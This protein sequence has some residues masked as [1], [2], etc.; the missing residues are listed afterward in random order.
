MNAYF[1]SNHSPTRSSYKTMRL[2]MLALAVSAALPLATG[3][4][5]QEV[6]STPSPGAN[7][8]DPVITAGEPKSAVRYSAPYAANAAVGKIEVEIAADGLAA[9]G[10]TPTAVTVKVFD[11]TGA[12]LNDDVVLTVE[13][14]AGRIQLPNA[15]T[16]ELG[17]R[18]L[19]GD[20]TTQGTQVKV[21][22]GIAQFNLL[23]PIEPQDVKMRVTAGDATAVGTISFL[24]EM[25]EMIAAGL[26]EGVVRFS[27]KDPALIRPVR[28]NDGFEQEL[29]QW[30][31]TFNN[32]KG[33]AATRAT[34]FIKGQVSG[35]TLLTAAYD[36]DK[37][38]RARLLRDIRPEAFYPVYGDASIRG[39][40]A[41]SSSK[42]YVRLDNGKSYAMYG[43]FSTGDGF[44]QLTAGGTSVVAK[45][46]QLGAYNRTLT[47]GRWH[48]EG[49]RGFLNVFA[50]NDSLKQVVEE[51]RANGTSGPY[52][53][54]NT[55]ALENSEKVEILVRDRNQ[56]N[57]LVREPVV[58]QRFVDYTFE[59]F[60]GKI[61]FKSPIPSLDENGNP[62]SI[63]VTYEVDQ[64]GEKFWLGGIDGQFNVTESFSLGGKIIEDRN[65]SSPYKLRSVNAGFKFGERTQLIAEVAQ[66]ESVGYINTNPL[67]GPVGQFTNPFAGSAAGRV[68]RDGNAYRLEFT[69]QG[70]QSRLRAY[71]GRAD[72]G[73]DN[74][75][76][77]WTGGKREAALQ[78]AF[79]ITEN[80]SI[81]GEAIRTEDSVTDGKRDGATLGG[82]FKIG[83]RFSLTGGV[84]KLRE[85]GLIGSQAF[86]AGNPSPG[87]LFNSTGGF[88]GGGIDPNQINPFSGQ[89]ITS[90][91]GGTPSGGGAGAD[92]DS[93]TVFL[94]ANWRASDKLTLSGLLESDVSGEDRKR[95]ELGAAYQLAERSR[96]YARAERQTG[97][98]SQYSLNQGDESNA[99]ILGIDNTYMSNSS[100]IGQ[101]FNEYRLRDSIEGREAQ[102][103][104]GLRNTFYLQEGLALSTSAEYLKI[105]DGTST[106][107]AAFTVG[108][109]YTQSEL[110]KGSGRLEVR[111]AFDNETTVGDDVQTSVLTTIAI[112][113]KLDR[114]WTALARNYYLRQYN[115]E[116]ATGLARPDGWQDRFQVGAAYRPVDNNR[117]DVLSKYEFLTENNI[118]GSG[119]NSDVHILSAHAIYH[120]SRPWWISGRIAGK[121]RDD[122]FGPADGN[123]RDKYSAWLLGGRVIYDFT[124]NWDFGVLASVLQGKQTGQTGDSRQYAYG[125]EAGRLLRQN[126]WLSAGY[127]WSGFSD[128][129]L[130]GTD[131]TN[132]GA[133]IR[134]RFKFDENLLRRDDKNINR[135]L[136]R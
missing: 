6:S 104:V 118:D 39:F 37:E 78:G 92:V 11:K 10:Q 36:S 64:G 98:S 59:P 111:R 55:S 107:A 25:R 124:E 102:N 135:S 76:S 88:F 4:F 7:R 19:D 22:N 50:A 27:R 108:V 103:A 40:E 132:Q 12:V 66:T 24:P 53:V 73:Y 122:E 41:R 45:I 119:A 136:D 100:G 126:L 69:H 114:N 113:R 105:L 96:V 77:G 61:L 44:T 90:N 17:S 52:S 56:V 68:D 121:V 20:R 47:G 1:L 110:W 94:G 16:D 32:G 81:F 29:R 123:A 80:F 72:V 86:I 115:N 31:R 15:S 49:E 91:L 129:D 133:Y 125:I 14:S 26:V 134:L 106:G 79:N 5:A 63:R 13:V 101:I 48:L 18:A 82:E 131:Y 128:D 58:L 23:A 70:D 54:R 130:V 42:L 97:L 2:H 120:P 83:E 67:L 34:L 60:S 28:L 30:S 95:F 43:D 46:D 127:N 8:Y 93:T 3:V 65:P 99:F 85:N 75:S 116:D 33:R 57:V 51:Y 89:P 21:K 38:T 112:A 87:S 71:Y 74:P 84:R 109:D 35:E 9:D 117:L 62:L